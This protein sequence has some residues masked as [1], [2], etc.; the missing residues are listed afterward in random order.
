MVNFIAILSTI[1]LKTNFFL[2]PMIL[3]TILCSIEIKKLRFVFN[4]VTSLRVQA[5][6]PSSFII[7]KIYFILYFD[8]LSF[9][10][11]CALMDI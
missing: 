6:H 4:Y 11:F 9:S 2:Q 1:K 5:F 3:P 8:D 7:Y 10:S